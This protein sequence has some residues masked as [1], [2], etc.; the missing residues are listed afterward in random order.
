MVQLRLSACW[1]TLRKRS[2]CSTLH[3]DP[4]HRGLSACRLIDASGAGLHRVCIL[5]CAC[6]RSVR[7]SKT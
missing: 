3:Q 7:G 5:V 2:S 1:D 4:H 6:A